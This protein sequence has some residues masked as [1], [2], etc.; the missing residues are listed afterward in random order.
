ME[1]EDKERKKDEEIETNYNEERE[2]KN[3]PKDFKLKMV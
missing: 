1:A 2:E 3:E